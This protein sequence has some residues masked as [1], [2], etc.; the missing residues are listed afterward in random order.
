MYKNDIQ[1]SAVK[2]KRTQM[3]LKLVQNFKHVRH[4]LHQQQSNTFFGA[5]MRSSQDQILIQINFK[6][7]FHKATH[8]ICISAHSIDC[9]SSHGRMRYRSTRIK[10]LYCLLKCLDFS[11]L[12]RWFRNPNSSQRKRNEE[13]KLSLKIFIIET[14][15]LE[16]FS[17]ITSLHLFSHNRVS[18]ALPKTK[19]MNLCVLLKRLKSKVS[20]KCFKIVFTKF[21]VIKFKNYCF[22]G[23]TGILPEIENKIEIEILGCDTTLLLSLNRLHD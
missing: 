8:Q 9:C 10:D 19:Q 15:P 6:P 21:L 2:V 4:F 3:N 16:K 1:S 12:R 18:I 14:Y 17:S 22:S 7:N 20:H 11:H 23:K 5:H 13:K